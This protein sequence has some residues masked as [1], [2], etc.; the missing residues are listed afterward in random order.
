M[1][2]APSIPNLS[3]YRTFVLDAGRCTLCDGSG[4]RMCLHK[5]SGEKDA[6]THDHSHGHDDFLLGYSH[7]VHAPCSACDATG[8]KIKKPCSACGGGCSTS[9]LRM[10][11]GWVGQGELVAHYSFDSL[12]VCFPL[13]S[14]LIPSASQEHI[15]S[16]MG[17]LGLGCQWLLREKHSVVLFHAR[18][19][20][21]ANP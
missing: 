9:E 2:C 3:M 21:A 17:G 6:H 14:D 7:I 4:H 16:R 15:V 13:F 20:F 10:S 1:Q 12:I 19:L 11:L 8:R 5:H 18:Y